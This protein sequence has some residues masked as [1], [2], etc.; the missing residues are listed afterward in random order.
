MWSTPIA[1]DLTRSK[2]RASVPTKY[3]LTVPQE[4]GVYAICD[5]SGQIIYI[6][7]CG[8]RAKSTRED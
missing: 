4:S 7:E 2:R 3:T 8:P 5:S 1:Y 6:G